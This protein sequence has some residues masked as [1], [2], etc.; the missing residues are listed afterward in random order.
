[1]ETQIIMMMITTTCVKKMKIIN[2]I[3]LD[4]DT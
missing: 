1:M 3:G 4:L 2:Q